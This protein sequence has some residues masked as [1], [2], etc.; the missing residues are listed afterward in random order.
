VVV[1]SLSHPITIAKSRS[2]APSLTDV[3]LDEA[4]LASLTTGQSVGV[5]SSFTNN[6]QLALSVAGTGDKREFVKQL[7]KLQ[8][9]HLAQYKSLQTQQRT[10]LTQLFEQ[11]VGFVGDY[12]DDDDDATEGGAN[13]GEFDLDLGEV[14]NVNRDAVAKPRSR[15]P[16]FRG[17]PGGSAGLDQP[18]SPTPHRSGSVRSALEVASE[19]VRRV[20]EQ[21]VD[22]N[23]DSLNRVVGNVYARG[24]E[25]KEVFDVDLENNLL[26]ALIQQVLADDRDIVGSFFVCNLQAVVRR[27]HV[28]RQLLPRVKPFYAVKACPEKTILATLHALGCG[29]DCAS[30]TEL[31]SVLALGA[32]PNDVIYANPCKQPSHIAYARDAGVSRYTFDNAAE[33][34]KLVAIDPDAEVVLRLLVDDSLSIM[35]FSTKFGASPEETQ[36]LV[37]ECRAL[38][39]RLVGFSFHV[40]SGCQSAE[41]FIMAVRRARAAFD[42]AIASGF[43]PTLL[44]IG[45][46]FSGGTRSE[47][48]PFAT[49][50][51]AVAPVLDELF[52]ESVT[53]IAEP[54][55]YFCTAPFALAVSVNSVRVRE[56]RQAKR[57]NTI[58]TPGR[59]PD[60]DESAPA[61]AASG[62][63]CA[64]AAATDSPLRDGED[65]KETLYYVSDGVYGSFN[66]IV[67]DHA[68]PKP[69]LLDD[70]LY[71]D[72]TPRERACIFGPTCDSIDVV[73]KDVKLP[74]L[75]VGDWLYFESMG[76][77]TLAAAS[78]FNGFFPP[79]VKHFI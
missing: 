19:R 14:I 47:R 56:R 15:Q 67:F 45:G 24:C 10:Q 2:R 32:D 49:V 35:P 18:P 52:D 39:A 72:E 60:P 17:V 37:A 64:A 3:V 9:A 20:L 23:I 63:Q 65:N 34:R 51:R 13:G 29:F 61:P 57:V 62:E 46:G 77:Y 48:L 8:S 73:A 5:A 41:A 36:V 75:N 54:G 40:G 33:L 25:T 26:K 21:L 30:Q 76:A 55:R 27:Y 74:R 12:D 22:H 53:I 6:S 69:L 71:T 68:T 66:N 7:K 44:D 38:N 1:P 11:Y 16:S 42:V 58:V 43:T 78:G 50:A 28:F 70:T 31:Q 4:A 59:H 79:P